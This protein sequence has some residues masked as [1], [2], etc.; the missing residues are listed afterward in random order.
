M[1][2]LREMNGDSSA[3]QADEDGQRERDN[4][5]GDPAPVLSKKLLFVRS[6]CSPVLF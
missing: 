1:K 4:N 6:S 5:S 2:K 3:L